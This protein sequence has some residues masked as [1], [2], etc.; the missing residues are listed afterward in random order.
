MES[1]RELYRIGMGP[2]SSH[3]MGPRR[4]AELFRERTPDAT[5][6]RVTLY[7]SLAA[8]GEG[9]L[10]FD[11][12]KIPLPD[13][14]EI[15]ARA[16]TTLPFHPNGIDFEALDQDGTV[17]STWRVYSVGGGAL[18]E[19][20][21]KSPQSAYSLTTMKEI[22]TWCRKEGKPFWIYVE[23]QEG[24]E[25]WDHLREVWHT[26]TEAIKRGLET[27]G[28]L[29]GG[30][31]LP[32][33]AL[34]AYRQSKQMNSTMRR[35][36]LM[37]A[38]GLA[39]SEENA[40]GHIVATAPTCGACGVLPSLLRYMK[41]RHQVKEKSI[42]RAMA[43][44][45]LV[46][47]IVKTNASISGAE[48]GCQGEVGT[49]CSMAAAAGAELLGAT[50][51]QVEY[52]AEMALEHHLGLTCDPVE[53]LVQIPCIE[54]NVM[55]AIRALDCAEYALLSDG[56]HRISFDQVVETMGRTGHDLPSLYRETAEG[57]LASTW[58]HRSPEDS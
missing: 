45:G 50:P 48:V 44:A 9:H 40:S 20:G 12:V 28:V 4:G 13:E 31:H 51:D 17:M 56:R 52:A 26:M 23:E 55:G 46:G 1:L 22:L 36:G 8:T 39:V 38:Y 41:E 53:G 54:R 21:E 24:P 32:R 27:E 34:Q 19:E 2:S 11:A 10:T 42:L 6:Y 35:T 5:R 18:R 25:I 57:G 58:A 14:T 7:G 30:I 16:D 49:A 33:K 47:N 43:T 37:A 15:I 29:P 3:T